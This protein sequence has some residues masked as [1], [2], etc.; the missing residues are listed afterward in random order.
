MH[1]KAEISQLHDVYCCCTVVLVIGVHEK[2]YFIKGCLASRV[3]KSFYV[4][5]ST[6][7]LMKAK[8]G[9]NLSSDNTIEVY[10]PC[11]CVCGR[12]YDGGHQIIVIANV[13]LV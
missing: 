3:R 2:T 13:G 4:F 12:R 6:G 5:I 1:Y 11:V 9:F 7:D 10:T 8:A